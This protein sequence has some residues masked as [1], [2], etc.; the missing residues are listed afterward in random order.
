MQEAWSRLVAKLA[1]EGI[2]VKYEG[3]SANY[4]PTEKYIQLPKRHFHTVRGLTMLLHEAGHSEQTLCPY[5][6]TPRG[7]NA[8]RQTIL[9]F[10]QDAWA[11][12]WRIAEELDIVE[13]VAKHYHTDQYQC[14][15]RYCSF[16]YDSPD[17]KNVHNL[18][19]NYKSLLSRWVS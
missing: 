14:L 19:L 8:M 4:F 10:E 11:R 6:V 2:E 15:H 17:R 18:Y 16:L 12:G 5:R 3:T 1:A 7:I 9:W 13:I